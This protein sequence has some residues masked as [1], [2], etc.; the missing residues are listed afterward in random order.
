MAMQAST[1]DERPGDFSFEASFVSPWPSAALRTERKS[2]SSLSSQDCR[3]AEGRRSWSIDL[4]R[5]CRHDPPMA[6]PRLVRDAAVQGGGRVAY[7]VAGAHGRATARSGRRSGA[8]A[9]INGAGDL[10]ARA[11]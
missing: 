4:R 8:Q 6:D 9:P 3:G 5:L 11:G 10:L 2:C 1:V 7:R